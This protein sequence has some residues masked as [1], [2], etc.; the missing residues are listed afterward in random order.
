MAGFTD[1]V[2]NAADWVGDEFLGVDDFG[3]VIKYGGQGDWGKALKSLGAGAFELGTTAAMFVPGGQGAIATKFPKVGKAIQFAQRG[4]RIPLIVGKGLAALPDKSSPTATGDWRSVFADYIGPNAT[5]DQFAGQEAALRAMYGPDDYE[6]KQ[7]ALFARYA[8]N[9]GATT[10]AVKK[11]IAGGY[12]AAAGAAS[13]GAQD[14]YRGG[15]K[16]AATIDEIYGGAGARSAGLAAGQ[17][18]TTE[19][20][21]GLGMVGGG[22]LAAAPNLARAYGLTA[23]DVTGSEAALAAEQL[24]GAASAAGGAGGTSGANLDKW[25]ANVTAGQ[26]YALDMQLLDREAERKAQLAGGLAQLDAQRA[27]AEK[28][29]KAAVLMAKNQGYAAWDDP[30]SRKRLQAQG[31]NSRE[32]LF[33]AIDALGGEMALV[34]LGGSA[35]LTGA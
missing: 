9:L 27:A 3:R 5:A 34:L 7:N 18:L 29:A 21:T 30:T 2:G 28:T 26:R 13:Q 4:R 19:G 1:W 14:I 22:S 10:D 8:A 6:A 11:A 12:G 33:Q 17:G 20:G 31:I 32:E 23:A 24:R 25:L 15:Q 35:G 16:A